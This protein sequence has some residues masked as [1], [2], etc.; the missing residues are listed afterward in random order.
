MERSSVLIV[1]A[2]LAVS[3][4]AHAQG[5]FE[6]DDIPGL[7]VE[8]TVQIDLNPAMLGFLGE[9]AK[10]AENETAAALAGITNVRVFVYEDIGDDVEDVLK[11][12][13]DTSQTLEREGWQVAVRV[14]EAN[15]QVRVF[16]KPAAA[17]SANAGTIEGLTLMVTDGDSEEA[18]FINIAGTIQPAQLGKIASAIGMNGMFNR[19][20]GAQTAPNNG[21]PQQE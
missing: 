6:F 17:G 10:G 21:A 12:V 13:D 3:N 11:F 7:D 18:V 19:V 20:P 8:P 15:E 14:R 2:L 5:Y 9:A 4:G 16:M 1:G